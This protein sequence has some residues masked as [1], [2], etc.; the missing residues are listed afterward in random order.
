MY[1]DKYS[2][3]SGFQAHHRYD[4]LAAHNQCVLTS[5][6]VIPGALPIGKFSPQHPPFGLIPEKISGTP[7]TEPRKHNLQ[8][9]V[10][11]S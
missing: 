11:T 4:K 2:Y 8:A 9:Y 6:E 5:T 7:F 1:H 10:E 3:L